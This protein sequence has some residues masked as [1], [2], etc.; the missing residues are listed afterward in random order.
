ME[1]INRFFIIAA[2][3]IIT[4]GLIFVGFRMADLGTSTANHVIEE[5]IAFGRNMESGE[6]MMYDGAVVTGSDVINFMRKYLENTEITTGMRITVIKGS[7]SISYQSFDDM[8]EI[9][10]F[11]HDAYVNPTAMFQGSVCRNENGVIAEVVFEQQ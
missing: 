4:A 2:G 10:N 1:S 3:L 7:K 11:S 5:Y 8:Q 9:Y 6:I